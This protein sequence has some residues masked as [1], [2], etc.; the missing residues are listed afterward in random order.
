MEVT[1]LMTEDGMKADMIVIPGGSG[2]VLDGGLSIAYSGRY[3]VSELK[4]Y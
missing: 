2:A 1:T 4:L 3:A